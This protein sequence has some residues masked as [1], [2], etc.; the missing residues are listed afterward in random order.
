MLEIGRPY[1]KLVLK[2]DRLIGLT[3]DDKA[4]IAQL[5]LAV[6]NVRAHVKLAYLPSENS[7]LVVDGYLCEYKVVEGCGRQ[8]VQ[9][10]LPGDVA[11]LHVPSLPGHAMSALGPAVVAFIPQRSLARLFESSA[12]LQHAYLAQL[13]LDGAIL[14]ER[15]FSLCRRDAVGRVAH[16]LCELTLRL[17][18][19]G[20]A[21]NQSL[22][23]P[24]TQTD[25]ADL[26]GISTVHANR[27]VQE[28]RRLGVVDWGTKHVQI[29]DWD[30]LVRIANF[31]DAYLRAGRRGHVASNLDETVGEAPPAA[32]A[33]REPALTRA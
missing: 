26:T 6:R 19:V 23:V 5:P 32:D 29:H 18:A 12:R 10:H 2:L 31:S 7:C 20:M 15:V 21:L 30:T 25:V 24:W 3:S 33:A 16:L 9:L 22:S 8:I 14:R 11:D 1:R 27:V 4:L 17:Q 13:Q 28:L